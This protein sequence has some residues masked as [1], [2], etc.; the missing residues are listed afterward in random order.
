[1]HFPYVSLILQ[2]S[3]IYG[4]HTYDDHAHHTLPNFTKPEAERTL[5]K[6]KSLVTVRQLVASLTNKKDPSRAG[7]CNV[8]LVDV[9]CDMMQERS[10][11]EG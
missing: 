5:E 10:L 8:I 1:M 7:V 3:Q 9:G 2:M 6:H 4:A 11:K